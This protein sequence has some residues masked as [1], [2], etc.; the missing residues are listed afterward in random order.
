LDNKQR[1]HNPG[2]FYSSAHEVFQISATT[3]S[4]PN[5]DGRPLRPQE[6]PSQQQFKRVAAALPQKFPPVYVDCL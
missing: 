1:V 2:L 6:E 5:I 3:S 4:L